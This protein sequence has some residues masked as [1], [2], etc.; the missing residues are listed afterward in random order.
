MMTLKIGA[1]EIPLLAA[2]DIEQNYEALGG[3]FVFRAV[4]GTGIKQS[5]W[6]KLRVTTSGGGWVPAGLESL[7]VSVPLT[8]A[9]IVPRAVP[10]SM[11]TRQATLPAAR[12]SDTGHTPW[13]LALLPDGAVTETT[14]SIAGN[15]ATLGAVA[16]AIAY[17]AMYL[18]QI[19]AWVSRP[20]DSGVRNEA[21]YRWEITC[22]EV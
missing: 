5:T 12:R 18:P 13:G 21:G 16:D 22:E 6:K 1:L 8:V 7:D 17:R 9:C 19:T 11:V 20:R 10:A 15:V 14:I 4:D 3:E 2:L